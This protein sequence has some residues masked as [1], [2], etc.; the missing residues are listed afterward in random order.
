MLV[1]LTV[2]VSA[3]TVIADP[4]Y[5]FFGTAID[6]RSVSVAPDQATLTVVVFLGTECPLARLYGGRLQ[7]IAD[8]FAADGLQVVGVMSNRQDSND[9]IRAYVAENGVRFPVLK[10]DLNVIAD[11]YGA[12]R[13]PEV[14]LLSASLELL[15]RGRIDDQYKPGVTRDAP[16]REDLR[17]AIEETLAGQA[18]SVAKTTAPGCLIG[19]V[20]SADPV[21]PT[22]LTWSEHIRPILETHC[23]ECHRAG[24]I[25]PF[26]MTDY[27]EVLGWGETMLEVID[28]GRMPPW[29]A[30]PAIGHFANERHMPQSD[31]AAL[32]EWVHGGMP[33]GPPTDQPERRWADNGWLFSRQ[34]DAVF[35]MSDRPYRVPAEG[36]VEYQYFV[37]DPGFDE[38]TWVTSAQVLPGNRSVVHHAIVFI[39]PPDGG[40]F[41]GVGWLTAYV[42]GQRSIALPDGYARRVPAGSKLVFQMHYTPNGAAQT[43]LTQVGIMT[44]EES[45]ITHEVFTV[46]GIDQEFEIPPRTAEHRVSAELDWFPQRGTLLGIMPHMHYRGRSFEFRATR[47]GGG[48]ETLLR[49][50]RYDFNWQHVY[51]LADPLPLSTVDS[52]SFTATFDNSAE[53]PFNPDPSEWVTWGDQT[54][55]EMAVVFCQVAQPRT[56]SRAPDESADIVTDAQRAARDRAIAAFVEDFFSEVDTDGDG[57][58]RRSEAPTVIREFYF[59]RY[60][61]DGD[62]RITR[63]EVRAVAEDRIETPESG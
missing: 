15:Y 39:R 37:V 9:D 13:T 55:E 5:R 27:E 38:D 46:I 41:R 25:A 34:P 47:R 56:L 23:M 59:S 11:A 28:D 54:W 18:V 45:A 20:K 62:F 51:E 29:H 10:D 22:A 21:V 1:F 63:Q 36:T 52:L 60:D 26:A 3:A 7:R 44:E 30:D 19:R 4:S 24:E 42:P 2:L 8:E 6:N 33:Q 58:V 50:P 35:A 40:Q 14:F 16:T 53:N 48:E 32:R 61:R 49:V 31:I 43:D 12:D 57:V 17:M